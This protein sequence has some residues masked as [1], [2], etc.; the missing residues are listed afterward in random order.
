MPKFSNLGRALSLKKLYTVSL[1]TLSPSLSDASFMLI[2][3]SLGS[4]SGVY[5]E[6]EWLSGFA[7]YVTANPSESTLDLLNVVIALFG[8]REYVNQYS[9][10]LDRTQKGLLCLSCAK[11]EFN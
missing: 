2:G 8:R 7:H 6:R 3:V 5:R 9:V 11:N 1:P 10:G 4:V